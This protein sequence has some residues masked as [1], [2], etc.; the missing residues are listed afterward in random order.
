MRELTRLHPQTNTGLRA[1]V[2]PFGRA[3]SGPQ[4]FL[5][6]A[7]TILQGS[8][9]AAVAR[10]VRQHSD[11]CAR[12]RQR[13][14][15]RWRPRALGAGGAN[16]SLML[17][18]PG[19]RDD[20]GAPVRYWLFGDRSTAGSPDAERERSASRPASTQWARV[21]WSWLAAPASAGTGAPAPR[22]DTNT[23]TPGGVGRE[24]AARRARASGSR[25]RSWS[26][27]SRV[28]SGDAGRSGDTDPG[29]RPTACCCRYDLSGQGMRGSE[30][31]VPKRI[32]ERLGGSP[33]RRCGV[34]KPVGDARHPWMRWPVHAGGAGAEDPARINASN[35]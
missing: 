3:G 19:A 4:A 14:P 23:A 27:S 29:F 33:G 7:L 31:G 9:A 21:A 13:P 5:L 32:L 17:T 2:R 22:V 6:R 34:D 11:P 8:H 16:V 25:L 1:D 30:P 15:R 35:T 10:R 24:G 28:S 20:W 26:S 18:G 12:T